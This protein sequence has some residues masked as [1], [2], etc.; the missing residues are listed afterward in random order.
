M[1][2]VFNQ[3]VEQSYLHIS[4]RRFVPHAYPP[5]KMKALCEGYPNMFSELRAE[6]G[7]NEQMVHSVCVLVHRRCKCG[8][9]S[10]KVLKKVTSISPPP[11]LCPMRTPP[12]QMKALCEGYPNMFSE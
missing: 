7:I 10:A 5:L 2:T 4:T 1:W 11:G 12:P 6:T 8:R 3:S 9:C